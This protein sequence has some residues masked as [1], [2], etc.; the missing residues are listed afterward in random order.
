MLSILNFLHSLQSSLSSPRLVH[1]NDIIQLMFL[2]FFLGVTVQRPGPIHP[3]TSLSVVFLVCK[4]SFLDFFGSLSSF[5]LTITGPAHFGFCQLRNSSL[6]SCSRIVYVVAVRTELPS[7]SH[8]YL[9][10]LHRN[11]G[12]TAFWKLFY[13]SL[14]TPSPTAF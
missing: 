10:A 5:T 9:W 4:F 1:I 3:V 13:P 6:S 12:P 8:G 11:P 7:I 2:R 14:S